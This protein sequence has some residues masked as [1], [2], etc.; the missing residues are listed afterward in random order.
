MILEIAVMLHGV[1]VVMVPVPL[2]GMSSNQVNKAM[3]LSHGAEAYQYHINSNKSGDFIAPMDCLLSIILNVMTTQPILPCLTA[4]RS[5]WNRVE[6]SSARMSIL[7]W[8][9]GIPHLVGV[10]LNLGSDWVTIK[11]P[12]T[13]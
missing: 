2:I 9:S 13:N 1:T 4:L 12:C 7:A 3:Q 6:C 11:I 8:N 10:N 5:I